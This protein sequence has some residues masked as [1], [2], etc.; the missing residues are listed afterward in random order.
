MGDVRIPDAPALRFSTAMSV[1]A[2][3]Y[4]E[5]APTSDIGAIAAKNRGSGGTGFHVS[6]S[7]DRRL[8]LGVCTASGGCTG[9]DSVPT[10]IAVGQWTHVAATWTAGGTF[11]LYVNGVLAGSGSLQAFGQSTLPLVIGSEDTVSG[12]RFP[13]FVDELGIYNVELSAADVAKIHTAGT[14]GKCP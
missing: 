6:V 9:I 7:N 10:F 1:E 13:G 12:R 11:K 3:I 4:L 8:T 5:S 2:W 14:A